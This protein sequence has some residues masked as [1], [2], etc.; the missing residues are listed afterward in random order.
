MNIN[1][2]CGAILLL[3]PTVGKVSAAAATD[4]HLVD[5]AAELEPIRQEYDFPALAVAVVLEGRP[6]ALVVVG[7]RK[8]DSTVPAE[9][10]DPFHLGSCTKAMTASLVCLLVEEG[11]LSWNTTLAEYFPELKDRLHA[12]Y[13]AV[14]LVHLL[15]HRAGLPSMTDGFAPVPK[16]QL[17]EIPELHP[18]AQRRR[19]AEI[20][21]SEASVHTPGQQYHYSN[22][23]YTIAGAVI[24]KVMDE[25]WENLIRKR[26]FTPLGMTTAGYG[27]MGTTDRIDAPWQHKYDG[28][29]TRPVNPGSTSDNPPF[30]GPG[31]RVHC[32]MADWARYICS[33][34]QAC[35][36]EAG[37]LPAA[38]Y[39]AIREPPFGGSYALGWST[40]QRT[41]GGHVLTHSGTNTM[42]Y[43]VAWVAP[44]KNF[45]VL[46]ATNRGGDRAA[47]GLDEVC[48]RM[49]D[50][51][52]GR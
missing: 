46:V 10:D 23:G 38:Q 43:S 8:A 39:T 27:A 47:R 24:E 9:S 26:L 31:G 12:N 29:R 1:L 7:V 14:T 30:L 15:S 11:R 4:A 16:A 37:L 25:S 33:V 51:F 45:A 42:N 35:R 44:A 49:I 3:A 52:L 2:L 19:V 28:K 50:R 48:A 40:C 21:L 22:A 32:S 36:Q 20:T 34:L 41:W 5:I 18:R 13:R 17:Q 6:R